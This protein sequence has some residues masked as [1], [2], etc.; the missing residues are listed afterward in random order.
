MYS[1][2]GEKVLHRLFSPESAP[3]FSQ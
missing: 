1:Y 3:K 2:P